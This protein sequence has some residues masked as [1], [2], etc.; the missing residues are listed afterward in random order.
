MEEC[1]EVFPSEK[2]IFLPIIMITNDVQVFPA[3]VHS[4]TRSVNE[5]P[6][7]IR[8]RSLNFFISSLNRS[9]FS[10]F[11]VFN[12]YMK[13]LTGAWSLLE[14][15]VVSSYGQRR[16]RSRQSFSSLVL[17][18]QTASASSKFRQTLRLS[19]NI[20]VDDNLFLNGKTNST[21]LRLSGFSLQKLNLGNLCKNHNKRD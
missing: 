2:I 14:W 16:F 18:L 1:R 12:G 11:Q 15:V 9:C 20:I 21:T 13:R 4:L 19:W 6:P 10:Q 7:R 8:S 5:Y 3:N 17:L